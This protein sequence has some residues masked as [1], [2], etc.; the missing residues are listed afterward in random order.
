MATILQQIIRPRCPRCGKAHLLSGMLTIRDGCEQCGLL[1]KFHDSGDGPTFFAIMIVGI[2]VMAAAGIVEY[3][4]EPPMWLHALLWI[5]LTFALC[6]GVLRAFKS[7]LILLEFRTGR[8]RQ[9][10]ERPS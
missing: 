3:Q 4:F 9:T 1:F 5:P 7:A 2:A 8:L 10:E 6:I